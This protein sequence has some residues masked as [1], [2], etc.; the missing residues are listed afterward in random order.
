MTSATHMENAATSRALV[1]VVNGEVL[2]ALP[3]LSRRRVLSGIALSVPLAAGAVVLLPSDAS[4]TAP[5]GEQ[6]PPMA[7]DPELFRLVEEMREVRALYNAAWD[8]RY[9]AWKEWSPKWPVAPDEIS[10]QYGDLGGRFGPYPCYV[11]RDRALDLGG[12]YIRL[13]G[14]DEFIS[15]IQR[16]TAEESIQKIERGLRYKRTVRSGK[17]HGTPI[18]EW[19]QHLAEARRLAPIINAYHDECDHIREAARY[20]VHHRDRE[21]HGDKLVE[22]IVAIMALEPKTMAGVLIQAEAMQ[23]LD[24]TDHTRRVITMLRN[25]R[26]P[27]RLAKAMMRIAAGSA[28]A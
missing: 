3:A 13:E 7:E 1:P 5:S 24:R 17:F 4:A 11:R 21:G 20:D 12:D 19:E 27:G 15:V 9:A 28:V 26:A 8:A 16:G 2:P 25:V 22:I 10:G 6:I 18:A 14:K 23:A